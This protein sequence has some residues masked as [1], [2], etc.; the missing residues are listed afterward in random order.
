M[1]YTRNPLGK[2]DFCWLF[3][4]YS[5]LVCDGRIIQRASPVNLVTRMRWN[6][7]PATSSFVASIWLAR[8]PCRHGRLFAI[9][10]ADH[11]L[12]R[13]RK[14]ARFKLS[15]DGSDPHLGRIIAY[16]LAGRA[17]LVFLLLGLFLLILF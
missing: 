16:G 13:V 6:E 4:G 5:D 7:A 11:Y 14:V 2:M 3:Q 1:S 12:F 15:P 9:V 8:M 10:D 17:G